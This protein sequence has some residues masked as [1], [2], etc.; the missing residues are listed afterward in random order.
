MKVGI[1]GYSG[2]GKTTLFSALTGQ[3]LAHNAFTGEIL[4]LLAACASCT[5]RPGLPDRPSE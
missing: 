5:E 3:E 1:V 2:V 4:G